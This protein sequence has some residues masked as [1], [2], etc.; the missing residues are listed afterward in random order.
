MFGTFEIIWAK[1]LQVL[2]WE[3]DFFFRRLLCFDSGGKIFGKPFT[4]RQSFFMFVCFFSL[5]DDAAVY[6]SQRAALL[7]RPAH[8]RRS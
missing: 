3:F 7:C 4:P 5:S 6:T 1:N 2:L 8:L